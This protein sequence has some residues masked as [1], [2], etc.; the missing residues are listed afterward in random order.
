M[1]QKTLFILVSFY[2]RID[3]DLTFS[4]PIYIGE[5]HGGFGTSSGPAAR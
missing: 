3:E 1:K 5:T 4:F 2:Q